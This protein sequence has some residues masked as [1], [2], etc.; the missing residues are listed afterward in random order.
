MSDLWRQRDTHPNSGSVH[1]WPNC[2][3]ETQACSNVSPPTSPPNHQSYTHSPPRCSRREPAETGPLDN[4]TQRSHLSPSE[5]R[6]VWIQLPQF[7]RT[8]TET[9]AVLDDNV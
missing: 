3:C 2:Y 7:C 5:D 4:L 6:D 1:L 8:F 9:F